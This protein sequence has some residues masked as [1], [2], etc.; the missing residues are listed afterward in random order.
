MKEIEE[1]ESETLES[2]KGENEPRKLWIDVIRGNRNLGNGMA[3]EFIAPKIIEGIAEVEI[4]E[5]D[6]VN[7]VKFWDTTLIMYVIGGDLSMHVVKQF[8]MKQ[9][10]FVKL[11]DMYYNNEGYFVLR[12]HSYQDRDVVLLKGPYTIRNMPMLLTEWK[13]NFNLKRDML[14]TIPVWIQLPQLPLH[15]WGATSLGKIGSILGTPLMTDEC[16]TNRYRIS[17]ARILVEIDI[18]KEIIQ[19]ITIRDKSGEKCSNLWST[20]GYLRTVPNAIKLVTSVKGNN[21]NRCCTPKF[22]L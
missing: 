14:R 22:A 9:W 20:N 8:M 10:N 7:E 18:T 17:Y 3:I 13:P 6:I 21:R 16:T 5:E 19:E 4:E 15:L 11:P 2:T 12:F 1:A